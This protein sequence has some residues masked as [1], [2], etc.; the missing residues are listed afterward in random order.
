[1]CHDEIRASSSYQSIGVLRLCYVQ[2]FWKPV[3]PFAHQ[4]LYIRQAGKSSPYRFAFVAG[5]ANEGLYS[6][7]RA[8]RAHMIRAVLLAR[9]TAAICFPRR[10]TSARTQQIRCSVCS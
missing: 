6:S 1:M 9:A 5:Y 2:S 4:A 3:Q 10:S 7:P 8:K